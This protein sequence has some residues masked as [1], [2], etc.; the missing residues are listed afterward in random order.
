MP[1]D[2]SAPSVVPS[3]SSM[4][5]T[6][7]EPSMAPSTS[8]MPSVSLM[9]SS[10]PRPSNP[11]TTMP[12]KEPSDTPSAAPSDQPSESPSTAPSDRPSEAPSNSMMPTGKKSA[13][14]D[15]E[16]NSVTSNPP[17]GKKSSA[18]IQGTGMEGADI[19]EAGV[20]DEVNANS[21]VCQICPRGQCY[22][23]KNQVYSQEKDQ[24]VYEGAS[25]AGVVLD[26]NS[27]DVTCNAIEILAKIPG[28]MRGQY[29]R[30][31]KTDA[32]NG[33]C[34]GCGTIGCVF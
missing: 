11:P 16:D 3:T 26:N 29:C 34:G 4:P 24:I 23:E 1:S 14:N 8:N 25:G 13:N 31:L 2:S 20:F 28:A 9:P 30:K 21:Q 17:T 15:Q 27:P 33:A 18:S 19:G 22:Q 32:A 12:S 5:S 6:S 7:Q 10:S